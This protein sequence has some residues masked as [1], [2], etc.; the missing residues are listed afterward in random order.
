MKRIFIAIKMPVSKKTEEL[1]SKIRYSLKNERI[2]WVE[3]DN[4]HITLFFLGDTEENKIDEIVKQLTVQLKE[5]RSFNLKCESVGV[6]KNVYNPKVLWLGLKESESF[7]NLKLMVDKAMVLQ[8][9]L[10]DEKDFKPHLTIGRVK[11]VNDRNKYKTIIENYKNAEIQDFEI[12]K[13]LLYESI[14]TPRGPVYKV[15][16]E[17][18]LD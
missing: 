8:G 16:K 3:I 1:I 12:N 10:I 9:C 2:N 13:V 14:L 17:F 7:N 18:L 6:F 11:F 15:L 4:L 5:A